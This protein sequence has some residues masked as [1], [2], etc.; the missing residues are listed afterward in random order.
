MEQSFSYEGNCASTAQTIPHILRNPKVY[1]YI[2]KSQPM[3][4]VLN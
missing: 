1:Y 3:D 2:Y 4:P